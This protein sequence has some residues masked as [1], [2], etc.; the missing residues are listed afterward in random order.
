[1]NKRIMFAAAGGLFGVL[2]PLLISG[3]TNYLPTI[4]G[5]VFGIGV[6]F[7]TFKL[8]NKPKDNNI[9]ERDERIDSMVRRFLSYVAI[10]TIGV[11]YICVFTFDYLGF[12]SIDLIYMYEFLLL[13]T[14]IVL[15]G[16]TIIR[17][18]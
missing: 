4:L 10:V 3:D 14:I 9:P 6:V 8:F 17:K 2:I 7:L 16:I 18:K 11:M 5:G 12:E 1:M 13:L 15:A